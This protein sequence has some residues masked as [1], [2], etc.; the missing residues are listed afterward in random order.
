MSGRKPSAVLI[1][2]ATSVAAAKLGPNPPPPRGNNPHLAE[3]QDAAQ[4]A[5]AQPAAGQG[6]VAQPVAARPRIQWS[7]EAA[8][9]S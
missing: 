6:A 2:S 3:E 4:A 7:R 5:A 1:V 9:S 8:M